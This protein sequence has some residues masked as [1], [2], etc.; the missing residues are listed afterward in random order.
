MVLFTYLQIKI[1]F[2]MDPSL[3]CPGKT[4]GKK[5]K[6]NFVYLIFLFKNLKTI[7]VILKKMIYLLEP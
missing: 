6:T 1:K 5:I 3:Y 7:L 4:I 2:T